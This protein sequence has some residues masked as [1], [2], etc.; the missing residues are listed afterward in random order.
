MKTIL[1]PVE[2]ND[3]IASTLKAAWL[4]GTA[5]DSYIEG[6]ALKPALA[7]FIAPDSIGGAIV[8]E[9]DT[10]NDGDTVRDA[11][12]LF[13]TTLEGFAR[14]AA[15]ATPSF[16]WPND[17]SGGDMFT[18]S[19]GRIFDVTVVGRPAGT[20]TGPRMSTLESALF[21]SGRPVLVAPPE[22]PASLGETIAISWNR[23]TETAR[24]IAFAK[25]L[26]R[27]AKRITVF[28]IEGGQVSGPS[29]DDVA[30]YLE[31]NGLSANV[32]PIEK[33]ER[34]F[35]LLTLDRAAALGADLLV[36]GAF[37]QGRLS[38]M[39]FGGATRDILAEAKM[40]VFMA[41]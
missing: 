41:H 31:R 37:T 16:A 15:G 26:L 8:Y 28:S 38:Q 10:A 4:L 35:G 23:S 30:R 32:V 18:G 9:A 29:G 19:Y 12:Q 27:R 3:F 1:V 34:G 40:P 22:P 7:P 33:G 25:P 13:E 11:R 39:I 17:A 24:T 21:E 36:K 5:F 6:F 2:R 14:T 20:M